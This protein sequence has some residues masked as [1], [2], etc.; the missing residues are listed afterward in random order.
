MY[1]GD[2]GSAWRCL[3]VWAVATAVAVIGSVWSA[4]TARPTWSA[5]GSG[6]LPALPLDRAL[7][8]LAA[9]ALL[10]C[11]GWMWVSTTATVLEAA[12]GVRSRPRPWCRPDGVRRVVLAACGVALVGGLAAPATAVGAEHS[13]HGLA[14]LPL[15]DRATAPHR[16]RPEAALG[17]SRAGPVA[18]TVAVSTGDS[19]WSIAASGLPP[20]ASD[21]QVAAHWHAIYALNRAV[22][23]PDPDVLEP[24][25]RLRLPRKEAS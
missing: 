3:L 24:G 4:A 7:T 8:G 21:A 6:A 25:Q 16:H 1:L 2:R 20:D 9:T 18:R 23:G 5:V 14:G 22:V 17:R 19:L 11:C 15:P 12:R 13:R 10:G